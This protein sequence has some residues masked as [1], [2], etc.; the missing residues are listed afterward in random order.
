MLLR[1]TQPAA[2]VWLP[3]PGETVLIRCSAASPLTRAV[4]LS[5]GPCR[6][7]RLV[8]VSFRWAE[9]NPA[10]PTPAVKGTRASVRV[11]RFG[12][13]VMVRPLTPEGEVI[14]E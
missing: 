2:P 11:W 5:V 8:R 3:T 1:R 14:P 9:D 13:P 10:L 7:P 12:G 4:V 6:D